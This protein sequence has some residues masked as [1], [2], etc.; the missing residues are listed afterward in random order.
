MAARQA[1]AHGD[2]T[3][4][5]RCSALLWT[6]LEPR[7]RLRIARSVP[8]DEVDDVCSAVAEHFCRYVYLSQTEPRSMAAVVLSIAA[9]RIADRTREAQSAAEAV[10]EL[11]LPGAIDAAL[12]EVLD[13]AELDQLLAPLDERAGSILRR[14]LAGESPEEIARDLGIT[15]SHL[16]VIAHRARKRLK[17]V[18]EEAR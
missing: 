12:D 3:Q 2:R 14:T 1:I 6:R 17:R 10:A 4:A 15:R 11:D 8:I 18:L 13:S 9:K 16:D 7:V 5:R